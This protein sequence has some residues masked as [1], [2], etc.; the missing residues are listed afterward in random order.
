MNLEFSHKTKEIFFFERLFHS[1]FQT[2]Q[3]FISFVGLCHL[4]S[5]QSKYNDLCQGNHQKSIKIYK[6]NYTCN[7]LPKKNLLKKNP[8]KLISQ[9]A[10]SWHQRKA[11]FKG[12]WIEFVGRK[13]ERFL[14]IL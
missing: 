13:K 11:A 14:L 12:F 7:R 2:K 5:I 8:V 10:T 6:Y 4:F 9:R 1:R 3:S